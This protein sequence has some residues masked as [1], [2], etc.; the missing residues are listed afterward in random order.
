M[1]QY[2]ISFL[3]LY[4]QWIFKTILRICIYVPSRFLVVSLL[5]SMFRSHITERIQLLQSLA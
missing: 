1:F 4:V 3:I 2:I 5:G